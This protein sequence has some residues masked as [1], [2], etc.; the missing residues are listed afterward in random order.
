[1]YNIKVIP[2]YSLALFPGG[3]GEE[4]AAWYQLLAHVC[5]FPE[6][7]VV[8]VCKWPVSLVHIC[9]IH[10]HNIVRQHVRRRFLMHLRYLESCQCCTSLVLRLLSFHSSLCTSP[11]QEWQLCFSKLLQFLT[12]TRSTRADEKAIFLQSHIT[13]EGR[14]ILGLHCWTTD[15]TEKLCCSL[16]VCSCVY[17]RPWFCLDM[18]HV[19]WLWTLQFYWNFLEMIAHAQAGDGRPLSSHTAWEWGYL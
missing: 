12:G 7:P 2:A 13:E 18:I 17:T 9:P 14:G 19:D 4:K 1:M 3:M 15:S 6:K 8:Y 10:F 11:T 5:P 16:R